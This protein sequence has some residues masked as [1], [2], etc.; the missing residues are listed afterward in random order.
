MK[1]YCTNPNCRAPEND[2]PDEFRSAKGKQKFCSNCGMRLVLKTRYLALEQIGS[3]GFGRTFRAWDSHLEHEC[4]I[5]QLRLTNISNA[6]WTPAQLQ[7]IQNSFKKEAQI[8]RKLNHPQIPRLWDSFEISAPNLE[9]SEQSLDS[10]QTV[11][12][13]VQ[14]YIH[15]NNLRQIKNTQWSEEE[16][17]NFLRQILPVLDYIHSQQPLMLIHRDI[18]PENIILE[19]RGVPY[20]IDFGAVKQAIAGVPAE[21]SIAIS[22]PGYASPE[23]RAGLAVSPSSDL[24]S[25]AATCV[26][27]LTWKNPENLRV[28]DIWNWRNYVSISDQIATILDTMLSPGISYR[29][30]S[31]RQV[32]EVLDNKTI[33]ASTSIPKQVFTQE[34]SLQTASQNSFPH[35]NQQLLIQR[36]SLQTVLQN[37]FTNSNQQLLQHEQTL[38]NLPQKSLL[39]SVNL[40]KK[41]LILCFGSG[42]IGLGIW[43]Y[44][45]LQTKMLCIE[46]SRFSCGKRQL[47]RSPLGLG[48]NIDFQKG[49]TAFQNQDYNQ[50]I[51]S[52][53]KYLDNLNHKNDPEA[54]IYLNNARAAKSNNFIKISVCV[55]IDSDNGLAKEIL[56]GVAIVQN[57]I[58]TQVNKLI[59]GKML[60]VQICKDEHRTDTAQKVAKQMVEQDKQTLGVIGHN[61]SLITLSA[62]KVYSNKIYGDERLVSISPT[63]TAVRGTKFNQSEM[64]EINEFVFRTSPNDDKTAEV[65]SDYILKNKRYRGAIFLNSKEPYSQSFSQTFIQRFNITSGNQGK[66]VNQCDLAGEQFKSISQCL[67][68]VKQSNADFILLTISDDILQQEIARILRSSG[69][70]IILGGDTSYVNSSQIS[71]ISYGKLVVAVPWHRSNNSLSVIEKESLQLWGTKKISYASAMAYDATQALVEGLKRS[72]NNLTRKRLYEELSKP[73]FVVEGAQTKVR[74]DQNHDRLVNEQNIQG[75]VIL[76]SPKD[77]EFQVIK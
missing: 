17:V 49:I 29:F 23:Q 7:Y 4:L 13:L 45:S 20:L 10:S 28:G 55:P 57:N 34:Q 44:F 19:Q 72:G 74:F 73:N 26:C 33:S 18:K 42:I 25:L 63:S 77:G 12:Y 46:D 11:F 3:G 9:E 47:I 22:T 27:L 71:E 38:I 24:Y 54:R 58:N 14:D 15:G 64:F 50:A 5:K 66:I 75:L 6:P 31:A 53:S 59:N 35:Q 40:W 65:L 76:V 32:M 60:L 48:D 51:S 68:A 37:S 52:F 62:A 8:L 70:V 69:D 16:V 41:L 39:P 21:Q 2:I 61:S 1:V 36:N 67:E 30:Q 43:A 56:R